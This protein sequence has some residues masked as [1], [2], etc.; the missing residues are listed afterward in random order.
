MKNY[1]VNLIKKINIAFPITGY[2]KPAIGFLLFL[3]FQ[4]NYLQFYLNIRYP[5]N[6]EHACNI[7]FM[8]KILDGLY[9]V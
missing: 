4:I 3:L 5:S 7:H 2:L 9:K 8:T 1:K 6:A